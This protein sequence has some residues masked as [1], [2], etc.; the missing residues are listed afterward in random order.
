MG[1]IGGAFKM[2]LIVACFGLAFIGSMAVSALVAIFAPVS[3]FYAIGFAL[4]VSTLASFYVS[5]KVQ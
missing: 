5:A 3:I 2:L 1:D 4:L